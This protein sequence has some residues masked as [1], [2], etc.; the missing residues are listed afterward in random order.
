M[1]TERLCETAP[2]DEVVLNNHLSLQWPATNFAAVT[3]KQGDHASV[4]PISGVWLADEV[5][6]QIAEGEVVEHKP[7]VRTR[8]IEAGC[9]LIARDQV[10]QA[11]VANERK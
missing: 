10:N 3:A 4:R 1:R 11:D 6:S 8:N 9:V 2:G 5:S 7:G